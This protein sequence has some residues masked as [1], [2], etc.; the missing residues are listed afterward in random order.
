MSAMFPGCASEGSAAIAPLHLNGVLIG[1]IGVGSSDVNRYDNTVGT[2]FL[3]NIAEVV[4]HLPC[5]EPIPTT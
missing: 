1:A 3:E 4:M 5:V 2:L